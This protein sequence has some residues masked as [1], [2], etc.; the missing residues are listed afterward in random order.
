VPLAPSQMFFMFCSHKSCSHP[1]PPFYPLPSQHNELL[2]LAGQL[3]AHHD[4]EEQL[5][6]LDQAAARATLLSA[7]RTP[8]S[9]L[10]LH[11]GDSSSLPMQAAGHLLPPSNILEAL[12]ADP[13]SNRPEVVMTSTLL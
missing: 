12:K 8:H 2:H 5:S 10:G 13:A 6:K 7:D 4:D 11:R 3:S 9:A 1:V